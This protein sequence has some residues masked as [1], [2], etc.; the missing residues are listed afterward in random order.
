MFR[1]NFFFLFIII[2]LLYSASGKTQPITWYRTWGLPG[3][4]IDEQGKRVCQTFDGGYAVLSMVSYFNDWF[5]ILKYDRF[6]NLLWVKIIIDSTTS[7]RMLYDM[8]QTSDSG[9]IFA[10]WLSSGQGALLI[11]TDKN[12]NFK[13]QRNYPNLNSLT[14]FYSVQQTK[15]KGYITCGD[16]PHYATST[17]K[18]FVIKVDSLGYIQWEKQYMDSTHNYFSTI[19]QGFD[20]KY[21]LIGS[22]GNNQRPYYELFKKFDSLG[23]VLTTNIFNINV[24]GEYILQL[25]DSAIIVGGSQANNGYPVLVKMNTSG[26]IIWSKTYSSAYYFFFYYMNKDLFDNILFTGGYDKYTYSTI[27]NWK[28]DTGG[29]VLKLKEI[30]YSGYTLISTY[31]IKPTLDSGFILTGP[32]NVGEIHNV[33]TIKSDSAFNFPIISGINNIHFS[34]LEKFNIYQNYPNPFNSSTLIKFYIPKNGIVNISIYDLLGQK[35]F[36]SKE[37]RFKGSNEKLINMSN[38]NLSSGIYFVRINFE[39]N[40]ELIKLIY[41]K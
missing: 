9:F 1:K 15:D 13:W 6:G 32:A 8:Q 30:Y 22:T 12:G 39:L 18:G 40:S 17:T 24:T 28:L 2:L 27:L 5:D 34:I 29:T 38:M 31:C 37:Y 25:N 14:R 33:I 36:T 23:N 16:Y 3:T 20:E 11:K 26:N 4:Q 10:G 41:L 7:G 21:Y 19:I 35:V